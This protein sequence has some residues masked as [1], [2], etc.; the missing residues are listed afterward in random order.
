[1]SHLDSLGGTSS[2]R[3]HLKAGSA[4]RIREFAIR[5]WR[6]RVSYALV[7]PFFVCF[8]VFI[9]VPVIAAIILS[10]TF[11]N[12]IEPPRFIGLRNYVTLLTE[13]DVFMTMVLPNT[14]RFA[15]VVGP[16]GYVAS[17]ILAWLVAQIKGKFRTLLTL[18]LYTPSMAAPVAMSAIWLVM[19]SGDRIG[20]LNSFLMNIGILNEPINWVHD[21]AWLMTVMMIVTLW[22]SMG[23]GFLAMMAG[24]LN[25]DPT[26]YEAGRIDG[27]RNRLQEIMYITVPAVK[28]QMLFGAVMSIVGTL[29]AGSI[30]VTLSGQ[31]PTPQYAGQLV[32]NHIDDYAFIRYEMGYAAAVSVVLLVVMYLTNKLAWALF[33]PRGDD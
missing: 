26:L 33:G 7:A 8:A 11:F 24:I 6:C 20:Y 13:D 25:V 15:V 19:F 23:V 16:G 27:V 3:R 21:P 32:L 28:P 12:T 4:Q 9:L 1:M 5:V 2:Q 18:S 31:N 22:G 30:G 14:F 29:Q 10:L 17:F